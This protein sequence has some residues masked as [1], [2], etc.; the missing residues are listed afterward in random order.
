MKKN[1]LIEYIRTNYGSVPDYPWI[2]Y[3]DYAVFRHRGNA[4]WFAIIMSVSADK[5]GAGDAEKVVDI[6]NVK[7]A[8]EMVG[9][10]RLKDGIY[11]AYHMNKE[12]WVT[13]ILDAEFSSEELKSLIDDSYRLTW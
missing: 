10:L 12:H 13:I 3:P 5:I 9:S 6:I 2:K 8:P 1:D 4:G 11:P 7:A